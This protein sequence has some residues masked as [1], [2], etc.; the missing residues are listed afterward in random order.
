[1]L[2]SRDRGNSGDSCHIT[3]L[4]SSKSCAVILSRMKVWKVFILLCSVALFALGLYGVRLIWRGLSTADQPSYLEKTVARAARNL[5][6]PRKAR[7]ER[8]PWTAAPKILAEAR[9]RVLG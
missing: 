9:E 8:N 3:D 5:A 4:R 7:L 2:F 6:I 1:M